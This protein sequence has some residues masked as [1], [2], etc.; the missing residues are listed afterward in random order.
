[1]LIVLFVQECC[2]AVQIFAFENPTKQNVHYNEIRN[3]CVLSVNNSLLIT[4]KLLLM[5]LLLFILQLD[6]SSRYKPS[7]MDSDDEL[8]IDIEDGKL[9]IM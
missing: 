2:N 3:K 5:V 7:N 4:T 1:M 9:A 6:K 8:E